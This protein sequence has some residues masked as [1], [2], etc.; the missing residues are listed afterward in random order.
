MTGSRYPPT[1]GVPPPTP[2]SQ[3]G[4]PT[5]SVISCLFD[6]KNNYFDCQDSVGPTRGWANVSNGRI[7]RGYQ[8]MVGPTLGWHQNHLCKLDRQI[9]VGPTLAAWPNVVKVW[10]WSWDI[11]S[12]SIALLLINHTGVLY[13]SFQNE[14]KSFNDTEHADE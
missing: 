14:R 11:S 8:A 2:G 12:I 10:E 5:V 7:G 9:G 4:P 6:M 13:A 1:Y 3:P